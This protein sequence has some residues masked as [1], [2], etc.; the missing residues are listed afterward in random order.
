MWILTAFCWSRRQRNRRNL[1]VDRG[2]LAVD[3]TSGPRLVKVGPWVPL[4]RQNTEG[5]K[6]CNDFLVHRS[7]ERDEIWHEGHLC[8]NP[9]LVNFGPLCGST[10]FR[11]RISRTLFV[12]AR[13]HF[14]SVRGLAN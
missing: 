11:Q 6:N 12:G 7:A 13:P 10:N 4:E 3:P 9:I 5:C 1:K 8:V 14:G 2:D